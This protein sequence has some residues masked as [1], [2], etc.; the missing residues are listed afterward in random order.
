MNPGEIEPRRQYWVLAPE[1]EIRVIA[2][3]RAT[4]KA[5]TWVCKAPETRAL[6]VVREDEFLCRADT[7]E[8]TA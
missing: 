3:T 2:V 5:R 7:P 1:G 6:M 4:A 8:Q